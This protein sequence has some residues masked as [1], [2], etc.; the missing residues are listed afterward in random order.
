MPVN[1]TL[2]KQ[3]DCQFEASLGHRQT[4]SQNRQNIPQNKKAKKNLV[5][6]LHDSTNKN[7]EV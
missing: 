7:P 6:S 2:G 3:E 4:L 5:H 1:L